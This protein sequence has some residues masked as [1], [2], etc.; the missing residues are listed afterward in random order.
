MNRQKAFSAHVQTLFRLLEEGQTEALF[1]IDYNRVQRYEDHAQLFLF[2]TFEGEK[3]SLKLDIVNDVA[4][5]Y[6]KLKSDA[7]LGLVDSWQ[8]ILSNKLTSIF[9]YEAKDIVD[10][11]T[12]ARHRRFN[13]MKIVQEAKTKEAGIDPVIL[14]DILKSFPVDELSIIKWVSPVDSKV[15]KKDLDRIAEEILSGT[16]NSI[17]ST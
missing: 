15:F 6:G 13:W 17:A 2:R 8:N 5:H 10:I 9:R 14:F 4:S 12:I 3:L 1:E 11:R 16:D 7:I